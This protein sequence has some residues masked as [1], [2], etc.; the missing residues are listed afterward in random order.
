MKAPLPKQTK[1]KRTDDCVDLAIK[2]A[3][4]ALLK[5]TQTNPVEVNK[6]N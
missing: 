2:D 6:R 3:R 1:E 4:K 5:E